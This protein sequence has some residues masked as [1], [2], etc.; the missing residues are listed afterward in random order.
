MGARQ[1]LVRRNVQGVRIDVTVIDDGRPVLGLGPQDFEVLD[2]GVPQVVQSSRSPEH[3]S[4]VF[5]LD[6]SASV[7]AGRMEFHRQWRE[8]P[9]NFNQLAA[10]MRSVVSRLKEGDEAALITFSDRLRL[11]VPPTT[12]LQQLEGAIQSPEQLV[13]TAAHVRSTVWDATVAAAALASGRPG[14]S[15]VI[16]LTDGTDNASWLSQADAITS[17][18]QAGIA[19]DLISVPRTYDTLDEDPPGSWDVDA[20]SERT[21]GEAFSAR[22]REL[23]RKIAE[24]LTV[25]RGGYV[26]TFTPTGNASEGWHPLEV[27]LRG[28]AGTVKARSGYYFSSRRPSQSVR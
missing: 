7:T 14:R 9:E 26:L 19:V 13:G 18:Q 23:S 3:L 27:R 24:R 1:E 8:T 25:L 20:I 6:T 17:A 21:G 12:D 11:A 5:V 4:V 10:A 16:L 28:R 15:I 2:K 22:D